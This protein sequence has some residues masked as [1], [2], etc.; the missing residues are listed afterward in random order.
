MDYKALFKNDKNDDEFDEKAFRDIL[1]QID[2]HSSM[3]RTNRN[4]KCTEQH[5]VPIK[6][7]VLCVD[8]PKYDYERDDCQ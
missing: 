3:I 1:S 5:I 8:L 7:V 6:S 4:K 2:K